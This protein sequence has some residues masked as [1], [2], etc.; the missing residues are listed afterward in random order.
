VP[1]RRRHLVALGA[2]AA[3]AA[4]GACRGGDGPFGGGA[5]SACSLV[6]RLGSTAETLER[7]DL[8]DPEEFDAALDDAV[9]QFTSTVDALL[10][11]T[12]ERL[13]DDLRAMRAAAEQLR[14]SDAVSARAALDD[15]AQDE[16]GLRP[17]ATTTT[18]APGATGA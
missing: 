14:F 13:H 18:A 10:E 6:E 2:L 15:W 5:G 9:R 1:P 16:C 8:A 11:Q 17:V 12:P 4:L 7:A 3:A